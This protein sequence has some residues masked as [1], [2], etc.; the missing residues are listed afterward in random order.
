MCE[1]HAHFKAFDGKEKINPS[2]KDEGV[3]DF[4]LL[5]VLF[6]K[7]HATNAESTALLG[8]HLLS[9]CSFYMPSFFVFEVFGHNK[10]EG[11]PNS[12]RKKE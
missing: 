2:T 4:G 12:N 1:L 8:S 7:P 6:A 5:C 10:S 3:Y 11:P 9:R